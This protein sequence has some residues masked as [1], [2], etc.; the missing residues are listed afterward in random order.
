[1]VRLITIVSEA[2]AQWNDRQEDR[3]RDG[4]AHLFPLHVRTQP[5]KRHH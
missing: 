5:L 3:Y 1:M 4:Q 2:T